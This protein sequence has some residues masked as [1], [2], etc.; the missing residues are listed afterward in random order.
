MELIPTKNYNLML[1]QGK[2]LR[3]AGIAISIN[4]DAK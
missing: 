2:V 3:K 1:I 4:Q